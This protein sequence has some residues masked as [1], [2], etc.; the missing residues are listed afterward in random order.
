LPVPYIYIIYIIFLY[1]I[2]TLHIFIDIFYSFII[3]F[4]LVRGIK[5]VKT[6]MRY[7]IKM[8]HQKQF[9]LHFRYLEIILMKLRNALKIRL[10]KTPQTK[11][12]YTRYE[13]RDTIIFLKVLDTRYLIHLFIFINFPWIQFSH[14]KFYHIIINY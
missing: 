1:F 14:V 10:G 7:N 6:V 11:Y 5:D 12:F 9:A 13:S 4:Q 2:P 3:I 8:T